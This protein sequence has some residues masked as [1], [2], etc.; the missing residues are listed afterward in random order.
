MGVKHGKPYRKS[1]PIDMGVK[2]GKHRW[3]S[4]FTHML[5]FGFKFG[6]QFGFVTS[7]YTYIVRKKT[8]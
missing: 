5:K 1:N 6:F 3:K 4:I 2:H 8:R 7:L